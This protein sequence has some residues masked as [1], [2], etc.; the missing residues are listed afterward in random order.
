MLAVG[1]GLG[2]PVFVAPY[3]IEPDCSG[4]ETPFTILLLLAEDPRLDAESPY[5]GKLFA[6]TLGIVTPL[7]VIVYTPGDVCTADAAIFILYTRKHPSDQGIISGHIH[8]L[9]W[10]R[11]TIKIKSET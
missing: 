5:A 9:V 10:R 8:A 4:C 7:T 3:A 6:E 11:L 2:V 1:R